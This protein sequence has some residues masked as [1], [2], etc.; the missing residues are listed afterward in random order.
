MRDDERIDR[1]LDA[2]EERW[3]ENPDLRLAQIVGNAGQE[4][5]Y[6]KDPYHMEDE[7]FLSYLES[8]I[9]R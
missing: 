9:E 8:R 3:K 5:G 2:L 6:G 4:N 1:L 7:E